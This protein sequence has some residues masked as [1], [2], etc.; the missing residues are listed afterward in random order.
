MKITLAQQNYRI[1]DFEGNTSKIIQAIQT[2][3]QEGSDL[4]V[5]SELC[6]CGYPPRDFLEF[7]DF[8]E[9]CET[10]IHT[11][12]EASAGIAVIIGAPQINPDK[13]GK[14][15]YNAA[16]FMVDGHIHSVVQKT[17][18]PTYDVF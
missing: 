10:S 13:A 18:L 8:I 2:A 11:I 1:G 12:A 17:C 3:R 4:V 16:Y 6:V 14:D 9:Q 15:L 7:H 5:F